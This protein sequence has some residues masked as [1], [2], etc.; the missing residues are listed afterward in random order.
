MYK[1]RIKTKRQKERKRERGEKEH[2]YH[3]PLGFTFQS[4]FA[5]IK[6]GWTSLIHSV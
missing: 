2:I 1:N 3:D 5:D 6:A 4:R